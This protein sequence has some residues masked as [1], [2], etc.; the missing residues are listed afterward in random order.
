M[1]IPSIT[2]MELFGYLFIGLILLTVVGFLLD[3]VLTFSI[4]L[5]N[6]A[7]RALT[8]VGKSFFRY[9]GS[10]VWDFMNGCLHRNW[11]SEDES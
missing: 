3:Y 5:G 4:W 10:V 11:K 8:S 2:P 1:I 7:L 9:F 6:M